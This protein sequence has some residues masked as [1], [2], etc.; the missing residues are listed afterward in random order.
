MTKS[1]PLKTINK[2]I[3][4]G[5]ECKELFDL[6]QRKIDTL[7]KAI[8][9]KDGLIKNT[10]KLLG[11][12]D[13]QNFLLNVDLTAKKDSI[14]KLNTN[15]LAFQSKYDKQVRHKKTWQTIGGISIALNVGVLLALFLK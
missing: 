1:I 12:E 10:E 11:I 14:D 4:D 3:L 7:Q 2:A 15:I 9:T 8:D 13:T 6:N 5:N